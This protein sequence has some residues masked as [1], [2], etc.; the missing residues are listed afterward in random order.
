MAENATMSP[1]TLGTVLLV[2]VQ[3]CGAANFNGVLKLKG[4]LVITY[5]GYLSLDSTPPPQNGH[6]SITPSAL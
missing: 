6:Y 1:P 3:A 2:R 4:T 5:T